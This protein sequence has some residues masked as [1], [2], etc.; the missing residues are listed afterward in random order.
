MAVSG[1]G[2]VNWGAECTISTALLIVTGSMALRAGRDKSRS[3]TFLLKTPDKAQP[4]ARCTFFAIRVPRLAGPTTPPLTLIAWQTGVRTR[5]RDARGRRRQ[6]QKNRRQAGSD[7]NQHRDKCA[8]RPAGGKNDKMCG[9]TIDLISRH[10][11]PY[12]DWSQ[13]RSIW[14]ISAEIRPVLTPSR[15]QSNGQ[16]RTVD[17]I[18]TAV[19]QGSMNRP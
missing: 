1:H 7:Q 9:H 14:F 8:Q 17:G 2:W 12:P 11:E 3:P 10:S 5:C 16:P 19:F 4:S 18:A 15:R 6:N 13:T